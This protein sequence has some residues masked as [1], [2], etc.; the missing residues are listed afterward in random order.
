MS[1]SPEHR[2]IVCLCLAFSIWPRPVVGA[3]RQALGNTVPE[4]QLAQTDPAYMQL[5]KALEHVG[6]A[7]DAVVENLSHAHVAAYKRHRVRFTGSGSI[8]IA[9]D[10]RP[11]GLVHTGRALDWAIKG[12]G[13]FQLTLPDGRIGYTRQGTFLVNAEGMLVSEQGFELEPAISLPTESQRIEVGSD[14]AVS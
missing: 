3:P 11:G 6:H 1:L 12:R 7:R 8:S 2:L 4:P 5:M 10:I 13:W 9:R 14:G